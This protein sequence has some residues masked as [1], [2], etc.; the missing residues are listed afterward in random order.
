[1]PGN[2]TARRVNQRSEY[3]VRY[4]VE[5][6][7]AYAPERAVRES[8]R[9]PAETGRRKKKNTLMISPGY[10]IFLALISSATVLMCVHYVRLKATITAQ[11]SMHWIGIT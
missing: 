11:L 4:R 8:V 2:G 3:E 1:M 6:T 5:G 10:V 7:A 9:V